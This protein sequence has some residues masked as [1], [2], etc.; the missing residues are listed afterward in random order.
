[1]STTDS[2]LRLGDLHSGYSFDTAGIVVTE[3]HIVAFAGISGDFYELHMDDVYAREHGFA[4][5]VAHGLLGLALVDGLKNRAE[6]RI[7]AIATLEWQYRFLAPVYVGDRIFARITVLDSRPTKDVQ[8]G[9]CRLNFEVLN[10]HGT[11]VQQGINTL[12]VHV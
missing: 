9:I 8:R 11:A 2:K 5:R 10:Q 12:L 4:G 7:A 6:V 3:S 1:M